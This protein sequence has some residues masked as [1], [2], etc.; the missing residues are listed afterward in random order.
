MKEELQEIEV[1]LIER[2]EGSTQH[3]LLIGKQRLAISTMLNLQRK[4]ETTY[5]SLQKREADISKL[6]GM[7]YGDEMCCACE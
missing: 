7:F 5:F 4:S 6:A 1:S 3:F 2:E